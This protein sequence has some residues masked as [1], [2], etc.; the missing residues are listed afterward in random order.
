MN[1]HYFPGCSLKGTG[2]VYEESVLAVFKALQVPVHEIENWNCCGATAYMSVDETRAFA[3][4]ARNM[5]LCEEQSA[6]EPHPPQLMAPC[7]ACYLV[8]KKAQHYMRE[9]PA[10]GERIVNALAAAQMEYKDSV[11]IR[12]PLDVL[13]NDIG[14]EEIKKRVKKS[15]KGLKIACYY[16]CQIVRPYADFDDQYFPMTMDHLMRA[17][18]AETIDWELKARCCGGSLTGTIREVGMRLSYIIL[19]D[20]KRLGADIIVTACPLCQFNLECFQDTM[21]S[22]FKE[23]AKIEVAYFTQLVGHALGIPDRELGMQRLFVPLNTLKKTM[24]PVE[25]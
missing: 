16:G 4:A 17:L 13:V 6:G 22:E 10:H 3:L 21:K 12:H 25:A 8:L 15:L 24:A 20:A 2:R 1:Y 7:N 5:A 14:L 11:Q 23:D 9:Y 18:G 19:K